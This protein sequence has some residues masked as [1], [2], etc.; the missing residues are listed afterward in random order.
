MST[1]A[2]RRLENTI[3]RY[4]RLHPQDAKSLDRVF[5]HPAVS[6]FIVIK[7]KMVSA[8]IYDAVPADDI[9]APVGQ[10][11]KEEHDVVE[12]KVVNTE[13]GLR[14]R[15]AITTMVVFASVLGAGFLAHQVYCPY[16]HHGG[17]GGEPGASSPSSFGL[18]SGHH[19][20]EMD[21]V[22][23]VRFFFS[24][25]IL[26]SLSRDT[27]CLLVPRVTCICHVNSTQCIALG[28]LFGHLLIYYCYYFLTFLFFI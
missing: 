16:H 22:S 1:V 8:K 18:R 10:S 20:H 19:H 2:F 15:V 17:E 12:A 23:W 11:P 6:H 9:E 24:P 5:S 14:R 28:V 26:L 4:K 21:H 27:L 25:P 7:I 13:G 3:L